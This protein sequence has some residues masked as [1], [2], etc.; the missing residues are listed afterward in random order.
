MG[1]EM[2]AACEQ[3]SSASWSSAKLGDQMGAQ[4]CHVH[5]SPNALLRFSGVLSPSASHTVTGVSSS[6]IL[7]MGTTENRE[8]K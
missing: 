2:P 7:W 6:L 5:Y 1:L 4:I 8:V 3:T